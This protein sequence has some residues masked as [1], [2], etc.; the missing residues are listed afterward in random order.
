MSAITRLIFVSFPPDQAEKAIANW[1]EKCAPLMSQQEGCI[2]EELLQCADAPGEMISLSKWSDQAS[3]DRYR[4]SP[5]HDEIKR[6]NAN[7][8]GATVAV[9]R[10]TTVD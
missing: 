1:K 7:I 5:A 9:K 8:K 4:S 2:S 10:Y 3:I 6:Q